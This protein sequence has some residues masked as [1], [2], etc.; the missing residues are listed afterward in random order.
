MIS[1]GAKKS[2]CCRA[3]LLGNQWQRARHFGGATDQRQN[4]RYLR[5]V[6]VVQT[7]LWVGTDSQG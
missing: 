1:N 3:I 2:L 4:G 7:G 5:L 6:P